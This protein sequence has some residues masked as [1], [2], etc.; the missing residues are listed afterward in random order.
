[1]TTSSPQSL[2]CHWRTLLAMLAAA[3]A[4]VGFAQA[5]APASAGAMVN[6][7]G[8]GA[9]QCPTWLPADL[10]ALLEEDGGGGGEIIIIQDPYAPP[11]EPSDPPCPNEGFCLPDYR[12]DDGGS[13]P[14]DDGSGGPGGLAGAQ[15][16]VFE[17]VKKQTRR[18][19]LEAELNANGELEFRQRVCRGILADKDEIHLEWDYENDV[20]SKAHRFGYG[21]Q[22]KRWKVLKE[23]WGK[24]QCQI[25]MGRKLGSL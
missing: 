13:T 1:M 4:L 25:L 22:W 15:A 24:N 7:E 17:K 20:V 10:C 18:E 21:P 14:D 2:W 5:L 9:A 3:A 8:S 19:K 11:P 23:E 12:G 6:Q 16:E